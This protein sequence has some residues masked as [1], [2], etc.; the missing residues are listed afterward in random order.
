[1]IEKSEIAYVTGVL[2]KPD[3]NLVQEKILIT[4]IARKK[5]QE[6]DLELMRFENDMLINNPSMY[7]EYIRNKESASEN[8][9][10]VWK[11]P[12]T[13]EEAEILQKMFEEASNLANEA[14]DEKFANE[15]F[16]RQ[17]EEMNLFNGID[18]DQLGGGE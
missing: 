17:V 13:A 12:E 4:V 5:N 11:A 15:E 14:G 3:L 8:E 16:I 1:M 9:G 2:T 7:Q 18:I 10:A 6:A